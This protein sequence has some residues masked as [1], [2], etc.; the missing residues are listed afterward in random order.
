MENV[1][2]PQDRCCTARPPYEWLVFD[3]LKKRIY[4]W[5]DHLT[6]DRVVGPHCDLQHRLFRVPSV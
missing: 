1:C 5:K 4:T 2:G 3:G 6:L